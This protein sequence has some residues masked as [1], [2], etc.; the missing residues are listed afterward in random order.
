MGDRVFKTGLALG[1][2]CA[3]QRC[4]SLCLFL[5]ALGLPN[6]AQAKRV[7]YFDVSGRNETINTDEETSSFK[8]W[9]MVTLTNS[10]PP[11]VSQN[12]IIKMT[13][14][15]TGTISELAPSSTA[16][17][18]I[19]TAAPGGLA[20]G[21][22]GT[23]T[24]GQQLTFTW[25]F[26]ALPAGRGPV[27]QNVNCTGSIE[28]NDTVA[29]TPGFLTANGLIVTWMQSPRA[30]SRGSSDT[31][32]STIYIVNTPFPIGESRPF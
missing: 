27:N 17:S 32:K 2:N 20:G 26:P 28:V 22:S 5:L 8:S 23:L 31:H 13:G 7:V 24:S 10:G 25:T 18:P 3:F 9:C 6:P 1:K 30:T 12:Y 11:T 21:V 16:P 14:Q 4:F 15:A 29:T 19:G